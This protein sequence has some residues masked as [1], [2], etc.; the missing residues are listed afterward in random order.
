MAVISAQGCTF[1]ITDLTSPTPVARAVGGMISF[2]GLDG[3]A[4][5]KDRTT[6]GSSAREF[7]QGLRDGGNFSIELF[8]E[9]DDIGQATALALKAA[10]ANTT[11]VLTFAGAGAPVCTF[12]A[13]IKSL[14]G[15]AGVDADHKGTLNI[16][17]AGEPVWS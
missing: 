11:A 7:A 12:P 10:Q 17:V 3:Q 1:T 2:T 13:Y 15:N 16:K 9:P 5:D 6:L 14:A 8:R 4:S